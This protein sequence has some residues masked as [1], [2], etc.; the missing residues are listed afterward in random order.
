MKASFFDKLL[1]RVGRLGTDELQTWL[2]RLAGEKGF[3]ETIF[4]TLQEGIVTL[5]PNG[6]VEYF[7]RAAARLLSLPEN[8]N[9]SIER[10]LKG[11]EWTTLMREEKTSRHVLEIHYPEHRFLELYLVPLEQGGKNSYAAIFHD[12]TQA[13]TA[14]REAIESE[15]LQAVTLLAAGVAHELGNPLNSLNIHLQL[16]ERDVKKA[17]PKL[18]KKLK[19]F[20]KV[21]KVE[22]GRLDGIIDQFLRAI[23]PTHP[24]LIPGNIE[25]LIEETLAV[26][27]QELKNRDILVER[28][29]AKNLPDIMLDPIQMKQAV[30]NLIR[31]AMQAMGDNGILRIASELKEHQVVI[32]FIDNGSGISAED[33]PHVLQP[34]FTTRKGGH[35]L[36]L[37]IVQRIVRE[38]GGELELESEKDHGTTVRIKLPTRNPRVHLL[39]N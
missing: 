23:R 25:R 20:F 39:E 33:L 21:A 17:P 37:M 3:L 24:E 10:Y 2:V 29:F 30:Y 13:Q 36:G 38:H 16:L 15:R 4:N 27:K 11:V 5:D 12:V 19:D 35:G 32:S 8:A 31:N 1:Q 14:T 9:A 28:E 26:L 22:I 34:Y 7:N 6:K 18:A